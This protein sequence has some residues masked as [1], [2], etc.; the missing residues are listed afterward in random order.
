MSKL[1]D[2]ED[3]PYEDESRYTE[4]EL[5]EEKNKLV[6]EFNYTIN[7]TK[8][9]F[10]KQIRQQ[11]MEFNEEINR[12]EEEKNFYKNIIKAILHI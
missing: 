3:I 6:D 11:R 2:F 1:E 12:L 8:E 5:R 9:D 4:K 7:K 10:E